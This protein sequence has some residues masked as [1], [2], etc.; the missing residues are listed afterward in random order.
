MH[1]REPHMIKS[2]QYAK[3]PL[4]QHWDIFEEKYIYSEEIP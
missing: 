4:S 2:K 3:I 1:S